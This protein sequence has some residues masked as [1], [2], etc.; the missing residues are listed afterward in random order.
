MSMIKAIVIS[1][2]LAST[3]AE[4]VYV[5]TD[6]LPAYISGSA[7]TV[8]GSIIIFKIDWSPYGKIRVLAGCSEYSYGMPDFDTSIYDPELDSPMFNIIA[9]ACDEVQQWI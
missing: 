1:S 6:Q 7:E 3:Q 5:N 8:L 4:D 9:Q 2:L